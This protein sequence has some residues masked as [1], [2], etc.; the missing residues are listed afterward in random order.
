VTVQL[1]TERL[2][3]RRLSQDRPGGRAQAIDG[4]GLELE[5][6]R[7]LV[8][9][10]QLCCVTEIVEAHADEVELDPMLGGRQDLAP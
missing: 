9:V 5:T 1:Q 3:R 10:A 7:Q 2:E 6:R 8:E 4:L